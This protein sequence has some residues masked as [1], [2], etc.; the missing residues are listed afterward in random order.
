MT[1]D[2]EPPGHCTTD[3]TDAAHVIRCFGGIRPMATLL[4]VAVSTVQGWKERGAIPQNR[5]QAIL[6]AAE[7]HGVDLAEAAPQTPASSSTPPEGSSSGITDSQTLLPNTPLSAE[8]TEPTGSAQVEAKS[9]SS[10]GGVAWLALAL[11]G[12]ALVAIATQPVWQPVLFPGEPSDESA[13]P[14]TLSTDNQMAPLERRLSVLE[15]KIGELEAK[16]AEAVSGT[17]LAALGDRVTLLENSAVTDSSA[18]NSIEGLAAEI[19]TLGDR[20]AVLEQDLTDQEAAAE[21]GSL[22]ASI[23]AL[24]A[25]VAAWSA[26]LAALETAPV[27]EGGSVASRVL[28]VGQLDTAIRAGVP[29][30]SALERMQTLASDD[31]IVAG[32]LAPLTVWAEEG[33]PTVSDLRLRFKSLL[34]ELTRPAETV[35]SGNGWWPRVRDRLTGLVTVR[36]I[37]TGDDLSPLARGEQAVERGDLEAAIAA[38]EEGAVAGGEAALSWIAHAKARLAAEAALASLEAYALD[39]LAKARLATP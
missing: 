22:K 34:P 31:F 23:V 36:R 17:D 9:T 35:S 30:A 38:L 32:V 7:R 2:I 33:I 5:H 26:R 21:I 27:S 24:S 10:N 20:L 4:G 28:A 12:A 13:R 29:F 16:S 37:G 25:E 11:A 15:G 14:S 8:F 19:S 18:N 39:E 3:L 1:D 6:E